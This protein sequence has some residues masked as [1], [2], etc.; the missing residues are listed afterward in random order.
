MTSTKALHALALLDILKQMDFFP[1]EE[2]HEILCTLL[3]R[4]SNSE[5]SHTLPIEVLSFQDANDFATLS[6]ADE[7]YLL[8]GLTHPLSAN[9]LTELLAEHT[10][11]PMAEPDP[12]EIQRLQEEITLETKTIEEAVLPK[13]QEESIQEDSNDEVIIICYDAQSQ[14]HQIT[15]LKSQ[16]TVLHSAPNYRT[17]P[18]KYQSHS[19]HIRT[20]F[21]EEDLSAFR[22]TITTPSFL[23]LP[24][25]ET[26]KEKYGPF[27][28]VYIFELQ[29]KI[30]APF[31]WDFTGQN[32]VLEI[33]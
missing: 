30:S 12:E 31:S 21:P 6:S 19:E 20:L 32:Q 9:I 15:L 11:T 28:K 4:V 26:L 27:S 17:V 3:Q 2:R 1:L 7:Q 14:K 8:D 5:V 18:T 23:D 25:L 10:Q 22:G 16:V 29:T 33:R 13:E 24:F